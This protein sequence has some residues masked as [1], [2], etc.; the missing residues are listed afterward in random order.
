MRKKVFLV[1]S[2]L[3]LVILSACGGNENPNITDFAFGMSREEVLHLCAGDAKAEEYN[4]SEL[5][6]FVRKDISFFN[7]AEVTAL[8]SFDAETDTLSKVTYDLSKCSGK[9]IKKL[10]KYLNKN[11]ITN[12]KENQDLGEY[13]TTTQKWSN[14]GLEVT[15]MQVSIKGNSQ[16]KLYFEPI[17]GARDAD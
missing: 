14:N 16:Y 13:Q 11:Y 7:D 5:L 9:S 10:I 4:D 3:I 2:L 8:Y 1:L 17:E 15:C 12:G 6:A